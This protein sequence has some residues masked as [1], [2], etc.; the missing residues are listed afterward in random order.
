M[1]RTLSIT[2]AAMPQ[3]LGSPALQLRRISG[4]EALS[5]LFVYNL[6]LT[7]PDNP[8][9]TPTVAANVDFKQLVGKEVT[10]H[11]ELDGSGSFIAGV[12][13]GAQVNVGQ[14]AREISGVVTR[15]RFVRLEDRRAIYEAVIEPWLTLATRS[16]DYRLFQ[17]KTVIEI[18]RQVL[19]DY[20]F[21][22]EVKTSESYP[23]KDFVV[24]YGETDFDFVSRLMQEWGI[25]YYFEHSGGV[26]R[27]LLVDA[28]GAHQPNFSAAYQQVSYYPPGHKIDQEHLNHVDF[29]ESLE[30]GVWASSEFDFK[31]P[32]ARLGQTS[33]LP[34]NTGHSELERFEWPND[35]YDPSSKTD[36]EQS[37]ML[38]R[39]RME[40]AGCLG[41]MG[42]MSGNLRG[43]ACGH[44]FRLQNYPQQR[45]DNADYLIVASTLSITDQGEASGQSQYSCA[46]QLQVMPTKHIYRP[47]R[48]TAL[49]KTTGPQTAIVTG[50]AGREIWTDQYGRVKVSF[51]WNRYC[52]KDENSSCWI[53]VSNPWAGNN[54]GAMAI[55]RIGQE[56]IVDFENGD[57]DRPIVTGRVY[58]ALNMPPWDLPANQTQSGIL[59][60]SSEGGGPAN[61]NAL[62]FEDL[63]GKEE[64]WLHAEKDQR[65]EVENDESHWVGHDRKKTIDHDETNHIKNDRTET[66]DGHEKITVHKTRTE[67]VDGDE[68]LT[69]HS[70]RTRTVDGT[71]IETIK[72]FKIENIMLGHMQNVGLGKM[73][74]VGAAYSINVGA[75]MS[76]VV[77]AS[78]KLNVAMN[79]STSVGKTLSLSAGE[80][81]ELQCGASVLRMDKSGKV[82]INGKEF[83]FQA[84]GPVQI[85]GNDIDL[86]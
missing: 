61:A 25:Y 80:V 27:M 85:S 45:Y 66:V 32:R 49:P 14:G 81:I 58:N 48:N 34:R 71:E 28:Q 76:T 73:V 50:P 22:L 39:I 67:E 74:N 75:V 20:S 56:V 8:L 43:M 6:E 24:Q 19:G 62:R 12:A 82:T 35:S 44:T 7:T 30:T 1:T 13:G 37:R 46:N 23:A 33:R 59:T 52:T 77:G 68:T 16:S 26:H 51:H 15:A 4:T 53:R 9:I 11:I 63:K 40:A 42:T 86:N 55:P 29:A 10:V 3:L 78:H 54:F 17:G 60:R 21:S 5:S 38:N 57:P 2:S 69:V 36:P 70:N 83:L 18:V 84:N 72:K 65:I 64:V 31:Q 47:A 41:Q 79:A